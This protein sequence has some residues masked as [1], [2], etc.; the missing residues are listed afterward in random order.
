MWALCAQRPIDLCTLLNELKWKQRERVRQIPRAVITSAKIPQGSQAG[1][2]SHTDLGWLTL[3]SVKGDSYKE[4]KEETDGNHWGRFRS[5]CEQCTNINLSV[6]NVC[7]YIRQLTWQHVKMHGI[8]NYQWVITKKYK[9]SKKKFNFL[10]ILNYV[11]V[12]N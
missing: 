10:R 9:L 5:L 2:V 1:T 11:S 3:A 4:Q 8:N 6:L 12:I 7:N